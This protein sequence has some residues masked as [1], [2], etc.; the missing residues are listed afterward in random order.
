[1]GIRRCRADTAG[2]RPRLS[3]HR[4]RSDAQRGQLGYALDDRL[5]HRN[6]PYGGDDRNLPVHEVGTPQPEARGSP[7]VLVR[8]GLGRSR[9]ERSNHRD[10]RAQRQVAPEDVELWRTAR[11]S[12][13]FFPSNVSVL[14]TLKSSAQTSAL[15]ETFKLNKPSVSYTFVDIL[16]II[17]I[18]C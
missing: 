7:L 13:I 16:D 2:N 11:F 3:A 5:G 9:T 6:D 17:S 15:N 10:H 18:L 1:M 4:A 12:S 8:A 14:I